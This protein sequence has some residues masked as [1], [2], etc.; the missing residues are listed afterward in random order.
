MHNRMQKYV[1]HLLFLK[2]IS[3]RGG[4]AKR[5]SGRWMNMVISILH[6]TFTAQQYSKLYPSKVI[7]APFKSLSLCLVLKILL[8]VSKHQCVI[9]SHAALCLCDHDNDYAVFLFL[10]NLLYSFQLTV[11]GLQI[12]IFIDR[13][14]VWSI[15]NFHDENNE[16]CPNFK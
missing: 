4:G 14:Y 15:S 13:T 1:S 10:K 5:I 2:S 8:R 12:N 3:K 16:T 7:L 11:P 9:Y 6:L